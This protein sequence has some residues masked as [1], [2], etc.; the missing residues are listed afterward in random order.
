MYSNDSSQASRG[1]ISPSDVHGLGF[2]AEP[3]VCEAMS[4]SNFGVPSVQ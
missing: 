4:A 2:V 3:I 1:V